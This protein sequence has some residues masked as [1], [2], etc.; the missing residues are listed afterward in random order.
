MMSEPIDLDGISFPRSSD[1][2]QRVRDAAALNMRTHHS[3]V[4]SILAAYAGEFGLEDRWVM[5][6][7]GAMYVGMSSSL[8]CG[9]HTAG[10]AVLGLLVGREEIEQGLDGLL[11]IFL[12]A[13]EMIRRLN[14][15]LGSP[16]CLE[17]TGVDF[18]DLEQA[19]AFVTSAGF[20]Q[21]IQRVA[22]G[23]EVIGLYLQELA[24]QDELFRYR[25]HQ[26]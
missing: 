14:A 8:T 24:D 15:K 20:E 1:W 13:Q 7:F 3:C 4:Q 26:E 10:L 17:L 25:P 22:D 5:R 16:T 6:S 19:Q 12:P 23:A 18:T 11:P 2:I 21:C 9:I